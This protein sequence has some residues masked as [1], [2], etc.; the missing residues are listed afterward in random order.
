MICTPLY[1]RK[2]SPR[3]KGI[4]MNTNPKTIQYDIAATSLGLV[5]VARTEEGICSIIMADTKEEA[6]AEL[7]ER[8]PKAILVEREGEHDQ[9]TQ[10]VVTYIESPSRLPDLP[11]DIEGTLFQTSV[12]SALCDIPMGT[13]V[14][15]TDIAEKIGR[16][17]SARAVAGAC[18]RNKIAI[19]IP[20]HRVVRRSGK[21][22]GYRWGVDRKKSLLEREKH[23]YYNRGVSS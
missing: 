1:W 21:I 6:S 22:S 9:T 23:A 14:S 7:G 17:Q 18:A 12:W 2:L 15:Y 8:F 11:L 3:D 19:L 4:T 13:T 16:P 5:L 20:C 10:A